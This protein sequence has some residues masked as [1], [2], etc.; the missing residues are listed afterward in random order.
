LE[1]N[2]IQ[3]DVIRVRC[4]QCFKLFSV[5][6]NSI[7]TKKPKFQCNQCYEYFSISFPECLGLEEV[8]GFAESWEKIDE[9]TLVQEPLAE[10]N[11][12]A[13]HE[14]VIVENVV[15]CIKCGASNALSA[16]ECSSCGVIF[17]K[18]REQQED[19][20]A[21]KAPQKLKEIWHMV[22]KHYEDEDLHEE[23]LRQCRKSG[24]LEFASSRYKKIL[25][26]TPHEAL[27]LKYRG[28]IIALAGLSADKPI[29]NEAKRKFK[30]PFASLAMLLSAIVMF[31][32]YFMPEYRN[33]MGIG[34]AFL[35]ITTAIRLIFK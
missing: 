10:E 23:F 22:L 21:A 31:M 32:G 4:P 28:K 30:V 2:I 6:A 27:A 9:E 16:K 26:V 19:P 7:Q 25:D 18:F 33:L 3:P 20:Y 17:E 5:P 8:V 29:K 12:A 14:P 11:A 13:S 1:K 35:F 24:E 34:A 15:P